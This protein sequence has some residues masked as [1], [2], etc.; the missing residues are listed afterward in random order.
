MLKQKTAGI[1]T[2]DEEIREDIESKIDFLDKRLKN[3]NKRQG[4]VAI[5]SD[6]LKQRL[7]SFVYRF[8]LIYENAH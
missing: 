4:L 3:D 1:F 2:L 6:C 5:P 8:L 7:F